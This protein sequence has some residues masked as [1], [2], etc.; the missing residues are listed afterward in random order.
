MKLYNIYNINIKNI[1]YVLKKCVYFKLLVQ[2]KRINLCR[3]MLF[4]VFFLYKI[5]VYM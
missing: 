4:H 5:R 2:Y 1:K 3:V